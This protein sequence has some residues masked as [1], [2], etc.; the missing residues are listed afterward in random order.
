MD[1]DANSLEL[2]GLDFRN[3]IGVSYRNTTSDEDRVKAIRLERMDQDGN[4]SVDWIG[5]QQRIGP[6]RRK[7][8]SANCRHVE[9]KDDRSSSSAIRNTAE[10]TYERTAASTV[11]RHTAI[12]IEKLAMRIQLA[13]ENTVMETKKGN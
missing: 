13:I 11:T 2:C 3:G 10:A 9:F 7:G 6:A 1:Q 4:S 8:T 12:T 5:S